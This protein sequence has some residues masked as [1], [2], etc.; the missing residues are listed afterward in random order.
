MPSVIVIARVRPKAESRDEFLALLEE[1]QAASRLDDGC[2]NYGYY[3]EITDPDT[4]VAVEEW[5]DTAALEAHL[6]QPHVRKL[7]GA[8]PSMI[9]EP[10][11]IVAHQVAS[12]G[13]L[14]LPT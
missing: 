7:I 5:R 9:A 14:P 3:S 1:V 6:G 2:E 13:P 8:L 11:S 12:S 10:P 4:M